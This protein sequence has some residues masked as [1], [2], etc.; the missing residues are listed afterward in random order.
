MLDHQKDQYTPLHLAFLN[1]VSKEVI[2]LLIDNGAD[3]NAV[4]DVSTVP[5]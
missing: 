2:E 5:S 3:V 1:N 4:N